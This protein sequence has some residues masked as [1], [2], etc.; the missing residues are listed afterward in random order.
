PAQLAWR[1]AVLDDDE[2]PGL[3]IH[4]AARETP[5]L[6]DLAHDRL[7]HGTILVAANGQQGADTLEDLHDQWLLPV[8]RMA[9]HTR[10]GVIGISMCSTP[11]S[12]RAST[13]ALTTAASAG[14]APPSP[15]PRSPR[16]F[17]VDGTSLISVAK[18]GS[19]SARGS[20]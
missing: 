15:P 3:E 5:C 7:R 13:T 1:L 10:S 14:V 18:A 17:E 8:A 16:G 9:S 20:A 19:V 11:S 6:D 4:R 2:V 12:A